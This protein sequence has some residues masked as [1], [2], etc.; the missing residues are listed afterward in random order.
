[1]S[2]VQNLR[3][4]VTASTAK[5]PGE[6][7]EAPELPV[8]QIA[9]DTPLTH[10]DRPFDYLVPE[11]LAQ[12]AQPGV[13]VR[14]RFSGRLVDGVLLARLARSEHEG[15]LG[16]LERV[17]SPEPVLS[18]ELVELC[19][20]VADRYAGTFADVVRLAVPPRH[21][22]TEAEAVPEA[23]VPAPVEPP[24]RDGWNRYRHGAALLDAVTEG[25]RAHAVWQA[26]PGE[27]WPSRLAEAAASAVAGG[28]GA[29]VVV[30]DQRDLTRVA[31]A[32]IA[33]VGEELV[34][35]LSAD[36]GPAKR[37]RSWLAIR[38]GAVK[39]VVGTRAAA[40]A[41]LSDPGLLAIWDDGDD[42]HAEP[43]AP[44]PH[45]RDVL[46]YRAHATG[47][48]LLVAG[49]ARTSEAQ[50]LVQS[51]WAREVVAERTELRASAPRITPVAET[52]AQLVD[53]PN[54]RAA[55]LPRVAFDVARAAL[56]RGE[57]VL[58]Q[59]PRS[60]YV[61]GL[62]CAQCREPA[63]CRRCAGPLGLPRAGADGLELAGAPSC[64]WCGV[65]DTAFRCAACGSR[66]PRATVV[67]AV[68]T[69]EELGRAFPGFPVRGSGGGSNVRTSVPNSAALVV[70]TPGAEPW[71]KDVPG[72]AGYGAV[73]LLDGWA[74]LSRSDL[75]VGEE[76]L[77]RW[78]AAAALARPHQ[79]GG[80]VMVAADPELAVVQA[81]VRWDPAGHAETEL[82]ARTELGFPPSV[83]MAAI[84][85]VP[86][87][88][89]DVLASAR[90]PD[91]AEILGPVELEPGS[92]GEQRERAL[93]RVPRG[94]ARALAAALTA[95]QAARSARKAPEPV[96][97]KVD[98]HEI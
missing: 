66:R 30:P 96:R 21:A 91:S 39:V 45:A 49:F 23:V 48:A 95:A 98:P 70:A 92:A 71:V 44:Y 27:D 56:G 29:L 38:R 33:S 2:Y 60:G 6:R 17:V 7:R 78:M 46:M 88:V 73:L 34:A 3:G 83:R 4:V 22:K 51:G 80:R 28:R 9:V 63:R 12:D 84:D 86:T 40:F 52:E 8:A 74:L 94:D 59:V 31:E 37:Y 58:V 5:R 77:R 76:T 87:A 42:L 24:G 26:V 47:A 75:R 90:F 53:D 16:W 79:A 67:G 10:L 57:P 93:V 36:M 68:R 35:Q 62:A 25:R 69:A 61:P 41:P 50:L 20:T 43:R 97:V 11:T 18:A 55:R 82:A 54:A 72:G 65:T 13:R 14:V 1:M 89:A 85:G 32:C 19:R 81:L 64:R 15:R